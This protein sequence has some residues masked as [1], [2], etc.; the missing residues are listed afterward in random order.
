MFIYHY[1]SIICFLRREEWAYAEW[2]SSPQEWASRETPRSAH[3]AAVL[4]TPWCPAAWGLK[5]PWCN[6]TRR[7][8]PCT[9]VRIW[10]AGRRE[11]WDA[12]GMKSDTFMTAHTTL[13]CR[14]PS[15]RKFGFNCSLLECIQLN[16]S[17]FLTPFFTSSYPQ[18]QFGQQGPPGQQQF[19]PQ[20]NPGQYGGMMMNGGMPASGGGGHMGQMG[21][22]MG[23]NPMV[24]GRMPMGPDQV[25]AE[26]RRV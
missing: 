8:V 20:G 15:G 24:M 1:V 7:A 25:S 21:G 11:A 3:Q 14:V 22:Q 26:G 18:Q 4:L 10:K 2:F 19:G 5:T 17:P 9:R 6:S 16:L 23:M 12:T 13:C